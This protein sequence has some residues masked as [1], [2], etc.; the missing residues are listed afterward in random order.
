MRMGDWGEIALALLAMKDE[1]KSREARPT[2]VGG[3]VGLWIFWIQQP[4]HDFVWSR[5]ASQSKA[6]AT[7]L[8]LPYLT[9]VI[10]IPYSRDSVRI[11]ER[12]KERD[13]AAAVPRYL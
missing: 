11:C 6:K 3:P 4:G 12:G 13:L 9:L 7:C 2:S 1:G 5:R 10:N 8:T